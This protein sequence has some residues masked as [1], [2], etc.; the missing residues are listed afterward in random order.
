MATLLAVPALAL[1]AGT[2][3]LSHARSAATVEAAD[4]SA[5]HG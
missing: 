3:Y 4:E 1:L 2:R 5:W